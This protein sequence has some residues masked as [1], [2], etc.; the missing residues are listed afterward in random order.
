MNDSRLV[1]GA[2]DLPFRS[3]G[4][5]R[6]RG[7]DVEVYGVVTDSQSCPSPAPDLRFGRRGGALPEA[8]TKT[9]AAFLKNLD[10]PIKTNVCSTPSLS[11]APSS[12]RRC[13][14]LHGAHDE[15]A[16][17]AGPVVPAKL[18]QF[19]SV[20]PTRFHLLRDTMFDAGSRAAARAAA[21]RDGPGECHCGQVLASGFA[22]GP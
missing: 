6:A 15:S 12:S 13:C 4:D 17:H 19:P 9:L 2:S 20:R 11:P 7:A 5:V 18:L 21:V 14:S 10:G 8:R 22:N 1:A 3:C 16:S